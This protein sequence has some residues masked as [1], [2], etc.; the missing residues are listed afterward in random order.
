MDSV[1]FGRALGMGA[2]GAFKAAKMAADA[3]A[4]SKPAAAPTAYRPA[5]G[6][7]ATEARRTAAP[8]TE[9]Q[10]TGA[11][12]AETAA[13]TS[14]QVRQVRAGVGRGSKR[15][16]EAIWGPFVKLSGVLWLEV[17][18][19]FFGLFVL[20]AGMNVWKLR[21]NLHDNGLN[22]TLHQ[23]LLFSIAMLAVFGYFCASSFVRAGRRQRSR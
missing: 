20:T 9:A 15:F 11:R 22:H 2:R 12:V 8:P 17:M 1:R 14:A 3:A 19:V 16:G 10:R 5:S 18:G 21:G 7:S 13:R 23:H 4:A 6:A